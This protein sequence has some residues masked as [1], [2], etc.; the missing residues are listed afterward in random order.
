MRGTSNLHRH[1][2]T[3]VRHEPVR[4]VVEKSKEYSE[5]KTDEVPRLIALVNELCSIGMEGTVPRRV[6][7]KFAQELKEGKDGRFLFHSPGSFADSLKS[8]A[9]YMND[10]L[11]FVFTYLLGEIRKRNI[12]VESAE[13]LLKCVPLAEKFTRSFREGLVMASDPGN[14]SQSLM[15][16]EI[17]QYVTLD[18]AR[19]LHGMVLELGSRIDEAFVECYIGIYK[20]NQN[21]EN[22][23]MKKLKILHDSFSNAL[24][25]VNVTMRKIKI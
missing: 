2:R 16:G 9:E 19:A 23:L 14:Q 4:V 6:S 10:S 25:R 12:T 1:L 18:L 3:T 7:A 13:P 5:D 15:S 24:S 21:R 20:N 11:I 22:V 17:S 8:V